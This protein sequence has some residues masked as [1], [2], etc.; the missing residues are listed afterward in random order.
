MDFTWIVVGLAGWALALVFVLLLMR[1][2]GQQDRAARHSE[3]NLDPFSDVTITEV[4]GPKFTTAYGGGSSN[5]R[6]RHPA[7]PPLRADSNG[8]HAPKDSR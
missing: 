1:M 7:G 3:K 5:D 2:S 8:S 6:S 4:Q